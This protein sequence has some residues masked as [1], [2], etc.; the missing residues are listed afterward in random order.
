MLSRS[1]HEMLLVT[2]AS[3]THFSKNANLCDQHPIQADHSG[4]VKFR[5]K[6]DQNYI[7]LSRQLVHLIRQAPGVIKKRFPR[8]GGM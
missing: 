5:H 8:D 4:M 7:D 2:E 1:G 6:G 3:A